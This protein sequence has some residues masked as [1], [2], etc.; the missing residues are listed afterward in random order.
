MRFA[1]VALSAVA[2]A[3]AAADGVVASASA[4]A[5]A[6]AAPE[7]PIRGAVHVGDT[8]DPSLVFATVQGHTYHELHSMML[9]ARAVRA[10]RGYVSPHIEAK[11]AAF[12]ARAADALALPDKTVEDD[13]Y[14]TFFISQHYTRLLI[15]QEKSRAE[16]AA[17]R[18]VAAAAGEPDEKPAESKPTFAVTTGLNGYFYTLNYPWGIN[19]KTVPTNPLPAGSNYGPPHNPPVNGQLCDNPVASA[20]HTWEHPGHKTRCSANPGLETWCAPQCEHPDGKYVPR[21][22]GCPLLPNH[23]S[24]APPICLV[25]RFTFKNANNET[26]PRSRI[27]PPPIK[28]PDA[29][30]ENSTHPNWVEPLP[31]PTYYGSDGYVQKPYCGILCFSDSD[32]GS[33]GEAGYCSWLIPEVGQCSF[34]APAPAALKLFVPYQ[35]DLPLPGDFSA[36]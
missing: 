1:L 8:Y 25:G 35:D 11:I 20:P 17:R 15:Q 6:D 13:E 30:V 16:T 19:N 27:P 3:F 22:V 21:D 24:V 33:G 5:A 34:D 14:A 26:H 9:D 4:S 18:A 12:E 7:A 28:R 23:P 29:Q 31:L 2:L 36:V 32:C 10:R